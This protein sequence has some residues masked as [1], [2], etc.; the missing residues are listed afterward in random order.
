LQTQPSRRLS[1]WNLAAILLVAASTILTSG[2]GDSLEDFVFTGTNNNPNNA[3]T[4][5]V[6]FNFTRGQGVVN[7]PATTTSLDITFFSGANQTGQITRDVDVAFA[8]TVTV[9]EVPTTSQSF[10]ITARDADGFPVQQTDGDISIAP[11]QTVI[12]D[13]TGVVTVPIILST[14]T[15]LPD[16]SSIAIG[17]TL[18]FTASG[19]FS[20]GESLPLPDATFVSN[21]AAATITPDGLA[22]GN[23]AGTATITGTFR[24]VSD[25]A[26]LTVTAEPVSPT[27]ID[28]LVSNNGTDNKGDLD[29]FDRLSAFVRTFDSGN[30]QGIAV[31]ALGTGYHNGD[32]PNDSVRI[33]SRVAS[34]SGAFDLDLDR[35]VTSANF[36]AIKGSAVAQAQGLLILADAGNS[37]LHVLGTAGTDLLTTVT[38]TGG[39]PWDVAY[40]ETNDRLYV[41]FT[42]G[43]LGVFD[44]WVGGGFGD[45]ADRTI[46]PAGSV[47]LHGISFDSA[48]NTL[49]VSDVG[50]AMVATDGQIFVIPNA[51]TANG[52]VTPSATIAGANTEL[53]NPVDIDLVNGD[54]RVAEKSNDKLLTFTDILGTI[55]GNFAA[56]VS[57]TEIKPESVVSASRAPL[58]PDNSDLDGG[59]T[60][61]SFIVTS[62]PG[63]AGGLVRL[64]PGLTT[65]SN[66]AAV[67]TDPESVAIDGQGDAFLTS[68]TTVSTMGRIGANVRDSIG[69]TNGRDREL[70]VISGTKGLDVVDSRGVTI[71]ARTGTPS[72]VV[73]GKD[74]GSSAALFTTPTTST[75]WDVDYDPENDRL[76][77]AFTDGTVGVYDNYLDGA[78]PSTATPDR[79]I[80]PDGS[81]NLHGIVYDAVNNVLL[82]SDVGDAMSASDGQLFVVANAATAD[83]AV[84][85]TVTIGGALTNLGNPV[86]IAYDGTN[87][88]V[89]EKSNDLVMRFDNIRTSAGG[90]IAPDLDIAVTKPES[91]SPVTGL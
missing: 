71:V 7:V 56:A 61:Q 45:T 4:G 16:G 79:T 72:I 69:T 3:T 66:L 52:A 74:S 67:L 64:N 41:A 88:Y 75:P 55:G 29:L 18:L 13:L 10:R 54:L 86:D 39:S 27:E 70:L 42:N 53:G 48:S 59:I 22:T 19:Q 78:D 26:T 81:V 40:D 49:V 46:E 1:L 83:G 21:S 35:E 33:I 36:G 62:N 76:Y 50:D 32:D 87:L 24:E 31:D 90:N 20:N 6:I 58:A 85:P 44:T 43:D 28:V 68:D 14:V 23:L 17:D 25:D 12:A 65:S 80:T 9:T 89:A 82:L 15:T 2:C 84:T 38:T 5:N 8:A 11:G 34:R 51:S 91:L 77:V 73:I 37:Q 63:G 60:L 57:V 47:N 30:N